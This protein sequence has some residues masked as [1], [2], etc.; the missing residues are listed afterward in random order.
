MKG[1][2]LAMKKVLI[3][4]MIFAL[5]I[6]SLSAFADNNLAVSQYADITPF[7]IAITT[8]LN[9]F[10]ISTAGEAYCMGKTI[11]A[12]T[13]KAH[14]TIELQQYT[15]SWTKFTSWSATS[16]TKTMQLEKNCYVDKGYSYRLKVTHKAYDSNGKTVETIVT[17]SDV[18]KY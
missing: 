8:S 15:K 12:S 18:V 14:T 6:C 13:Y 2:D 10:D 5:C 1:G 4:L 3:V 7:N 9:K 16:S 17:Y 11:T